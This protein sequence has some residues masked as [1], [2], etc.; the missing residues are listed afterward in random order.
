MT[1]VI[2]KIS[3]TIEFLYKDLFIENDDY[4]YF[5]VLFTQE[6]DT[7][8]N[9]FILGKPF[10]KK[11]PVVFNVNRKKEKIGFYNNLFLVEENENHTIYNNDNNNSNNY[12][13][14]TFILIIIGICILGL[15]IYIIVKYFKKPREQKVNELIEFFDYSS[16]QQKI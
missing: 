14:L 7:L 10:F 11:Y 5:N 9:S 16:V 12:N 1:I 4:V 2:D 15:L 8:K 6:E 13:K 3:Y